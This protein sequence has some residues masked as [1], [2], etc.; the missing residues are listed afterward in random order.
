MQIDRGAYIVDDGN[1]TDMRL[2]EYKLWDSSI[3]VT[4]FQSELIDQGYESS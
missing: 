3:V 2:Y 1:I 4:A